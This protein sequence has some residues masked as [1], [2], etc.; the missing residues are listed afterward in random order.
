M[1]RPY[2]ITKEIQI[3]KIDR[4]TKPNLTNQNMGNKNKKGTKN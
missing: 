2:L 1:Q 3:Y 4:L